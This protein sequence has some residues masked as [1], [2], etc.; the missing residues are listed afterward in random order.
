MFCV[1]VTLMHVR[2]SREVR[3][4]A[5]VASRPW[6][7]L[8]KDAQFYVKHSHIPDLYQQCIQSRLRRVSVTKCCKPV[9]RA[10]QMT[11]APATSS[12]ALK[13]CSINLFLTLISVTI[14]STLAKVVRSRAVLP[15]NPDTRYVSGSRIAAGGLLTA[16]ATFCI[17][18][19]SV[20]AGEIPESVL[21]R[22][23][24]QM[25]ERDAMLGLYPR[26]LFLL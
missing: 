14:P 9:P 13:S 24:E 17:T 7:T 3:F 19:R 26:S 8:R 5:I 6:V 2:A 18:G 22:K 20:E 15:R 11:G 1:H 25:K 16:Q 10:P 23:M 21:F 4:E 12:M